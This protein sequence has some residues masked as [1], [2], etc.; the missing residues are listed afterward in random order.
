MINIILSQFGRQEIMIDSIKSLLE[1]E[2]K[3]VLE[4]NSNRLVI[5][6]LPLK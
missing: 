1:I 3:S 5:V 2:V 4:T 6:D